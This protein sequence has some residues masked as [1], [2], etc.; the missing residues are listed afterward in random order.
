MYKCEPKMETKGGEIFGLLV[1]RLLNALY[2]KI[3]GYKEHQKIISQAAPDLVF[4]L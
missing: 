2:I 3:R 1:Y 4:S